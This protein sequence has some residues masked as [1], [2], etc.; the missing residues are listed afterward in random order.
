M[1]KRR[2]AIAMTDEEMWDF[3]ESRKSIQVATL[4][5]DGSPHLT[6]LWFAV[7]DGKIVL[8]TFTKSQKVVNLER[9]PRI[10]LLLEAGESYDQLR[11]VSIN[12]TAEL[13]REVDEVH[14]LHTAVLVRNQ[15]D[16]PADV[17]DK[18]SAGMAHKKTAIL[19]KPERVMSWDH[20]KLGGIY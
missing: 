20:T 6:T 10:A 11:G 9:D 1:P 16:V 5:R 15:P 7:A 14:R 18:V 4:N 3:I 13:V 2:D 8:E 12:A 19:V 17:L